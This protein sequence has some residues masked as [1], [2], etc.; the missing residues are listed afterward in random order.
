MGRGGD[1]RDDPVHGLCLGVRADAGYSRVP[2]AAAQDGAFFRWFDAL[3]PK[4]EFPHRSLLLVGTLCIVASFFSLVQI[5][6]ALVLARVLVVFVGQIV[7]LH[8][9]RRYRHEIN[10]PFKVWLYPLP[11]LLALAGWLFVFFSPLFQPGGWRFMLYAFGTIIL[12]L[13]AFFVL[14]ARKGEWP[15]PQRSR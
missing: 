10:R 14:A 7:G 4:G 11:A 12:G 6:T 3:H 8:I 1:F 9:I 13:V 5:I 15:F 2:Y